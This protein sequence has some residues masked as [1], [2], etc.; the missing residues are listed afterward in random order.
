MRIFLLVL[1]VF[2]ITVYADSSVECDTAKELDRQKSG[3]THNTLILGW[4]KMEDHKLLNEADIP[5]SCAWIKSPIWAKGSFPVNEGDEAT[6]EGCVYTKGNNCISKYS[7]RVHNCGEHNVYYLN[8]TATQDEAYC[9]TRE[10]DYDDDDDCEEQTKDYGKKFHRCHRNNRHVV[11]VIGSIII[12]GVIIAMV[13]IYLWR[14]KRLAAL[15]RKE[16]YKET[17]QHRDGPVVVT[18]NDNLP[19]KK[20]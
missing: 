13:A 8:A 6:L 7:I 17:P 5:A 2:S 1:L 11:L 19:P 18:T 4:Y 9:F 14:R 12:V 3:N 15:L 16:M 20:Y 10:K